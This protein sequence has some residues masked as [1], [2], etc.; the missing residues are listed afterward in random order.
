MKTRTEKTIPSFI[1]GLKLSEYDTALCLLIDILNKEVLKM[2]KEPQN[3]R[4]FKGNI[5]QGL[6]VNETTINGY[7]RGKGKS[8]G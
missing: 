5:S 7:K 8:P 3:N 4:C 2:L 6:E 1:K